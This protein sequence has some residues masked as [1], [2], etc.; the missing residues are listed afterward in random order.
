M[1]KE[2]CKVRKTK[3]RGSGIFAAKSIPAGSVILFE[4]PFQKIVFSSDKNTVCD[5]CLQPAKQRCAGCKQVQFCSKPCL[6]NAWSDYHKNE[7][8]LLKKAKADFLG[9]KLTDTRVQKILAVTRCLLTVGFEAAEN[10]HKLKLHDNS[11][12]EHVSQDVKRLVEYLGTD[13]MKKLCIN[14]DQITKLFLQYLGNH[15]V[16]EPEDYAKEPDDEVEPINFQAEGLFLEAS[17]MNHS[18]FPNTNR[19]FTSDGEMFVT[20]RV[21]IKEGEEILGTYLDTCLPREDR[22]NDLLYYHQFECECQKCEEETVPFDI[23]GEKLM[24]KLR[25][26]RPDHMQ[27]MQCVDENKNDGLDINIVKLA[28]YL[29]SFYYSMQDFNQAARYGQIGVDLGQRNL[30][31]RHDISQGI[32]SLNL[33]K[34]YIFLQNGLSA[35]MSYQLAKNI[36]GKSH[37]YKNSKIMKNLADWGKVV[38]NF[39]KVSS[40]EMKEL[41]A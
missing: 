9:K 20:A 40:S 30:F 33:A 10:L 14:E 28:E 15:Y 2:L 34:C 4:E 39:S 29:F 5:W 18:C 24:A 38:E 21:D 11:Q 27:I 7:C 23:T 37:N 22:Y 31:H 19:C 32:L 1:N 36:L 8:K 16:I 6:S 35:S 17:L 25:E 26:K 41:L 12:A 3:D 13:N